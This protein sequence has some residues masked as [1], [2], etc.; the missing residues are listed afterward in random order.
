MDR[1]GNLV[2]WLGRIIYLILRPIAKMRY[3]NKDIWLVSERGTDARDNGYHM[4]KYLRKE[5]PEINAWYVITRDSVDLKKIIDFGNIVYSGTIKYWMLYIGSSVILTAFEPIVPSAN[6]KF[7]QYVTKKN[8]QKVVFL[9]HG[10]TSEDICCYHKEC[11]NYDLFICGAKPEYDFVLNTF[12]YSPSEVKYTGF[13]RF[14]S[15]HSI[16]TKR[17]VLIMPTWRKWLKNSSKQEVIN[18]E[19]VEKWN[20][21]LESPKLIEIAEKSETKIIFYPHQEMQKFV[22]A[23][24]S[25]NSNIIIGDCKE[26]DVQPLLMESSLLITDYSSVNFDFA[27]MKKPVMYYQFDDERIFRDHYDNGWFDYRNLGFGEVTQ[28]EEVLL[29]LLE[30]YISNDFK[31]SAQYRQRIE[32]FFPLYDEY[33]SERIFREIE[34]MG[35]N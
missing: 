26:F 11:A 33:N 32:S 35:K 9:Q 5:H 31:I 22:D 4:F 2:Y 25:S 18:S 8:H 34:I 14:D 6:R 1:N 19:Y 15:L 7:G 29:E 12:N 10:I 27:Y 24:R 16:K 30:K 23:F 17:Q 13:A 21:L 20:H 3:K 28:S